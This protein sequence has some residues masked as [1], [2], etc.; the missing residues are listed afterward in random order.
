MDLE[1]D[2]IIHPERY[3]LVSRVYEA[4]EPY[5]GQ[6]READADLGRIDDAVLALLHITL[7]DGDRAWKGFDFEVM[8]RLCEKG[9]ILDP[10]GK[11][12]SVVL[13]GEGLAPCSVATSSSFQVRCARSSA[14]FHVRV[15][16]VLTSPVTAIRV[17]LTWPRSSRHTEAACAR[18]APNS[19]VIPEV[20]SRS[21]S[22]G[23]NKTKFE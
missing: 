14:V 15:A 3:P 22:R 19:G 1:I 4:H 21:S 10:R 12:K 16:V 8:E 7:H 11:S 9:Y 5:A 13:T 17:G 20:P 23:S 18:Q 6:K 2:S